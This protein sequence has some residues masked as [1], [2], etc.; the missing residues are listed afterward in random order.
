M[1]TWLEITTGEWISNV[2]LVAHT[3]GYMIPDPAVGIDATQA[4]TG[5]LALSVDTGLIRWT[6]GVDDTFWSAVGR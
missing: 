6:I 3:D 1:L 2:S 5:I 4:G